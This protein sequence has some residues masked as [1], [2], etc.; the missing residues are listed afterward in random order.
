MGVKVVFSEQLQ[1][2][3]CMDEYNDISTDDDK[4]IEDVNKTDEDDPT[5]TQKCN[6]LRQYLNE[7]NAKYSHCFTG[8]DSVYFLYTI[9]SINGA[10][11]KCTN[12]K[13]RLELESHRTKSIHVESKLGEKYS[14]VDHS[15]KGTVSPGEEG[16]ATSECKEETCK[17]KHLENQEQSE[18]GGTRGG[19]PDSRSEQITSGSS[20][21]LEAP[22]DT[23]STGHEVLGTISH[24]SSADSEGIP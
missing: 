4:K 9:S 12:Y 16:E 6:I 2:K 7:Y 24:V 20:Q 19:E 5:F 17:T 8:E 23:L 1:G 18:R 21:E 14:Q 22:T 11:T 15:A 3:T 10:L 13:R